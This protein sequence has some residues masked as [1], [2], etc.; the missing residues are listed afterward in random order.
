M[1]LDAYAGTGA[2]GIEALSRGARR[3]IFIEKS[4]AAVGVIRENLTT[5]GIAQRAEVLHGR[6]LQYLA[7]RSA[8]IVFLDPPYDLEKEYGEAL[9]VLAAGAAKVVIAQHASRFQLE[10]A[11]WALERREKR[12]AGRQYVKL[13]STC[14]FCLTRMHGSRRIGRHLSR[15]RREV[16]LFSP[17]RCPT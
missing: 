1:F 6:T 8:D 17:L 13:L 3:G 9:T 4:R 7:Q 11:V 16:T 14:R 5:L 10:G 12:E 15:D 2:V